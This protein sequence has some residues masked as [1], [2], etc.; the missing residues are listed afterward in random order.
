MA[1]TL[2]KRDITSNRDWRTLYGAHIP[3]LTCGDRVILEG[4]PD[5]NEVVQAMSQLG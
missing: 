2:I 3:V 1:I 4:R 5:L